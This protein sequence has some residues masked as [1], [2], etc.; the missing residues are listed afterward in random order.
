MR[1]KLILTPLG[2]KIKYRI[3]GKRFCKEMNQEQHNSG[4][5]SRDDLFWKSIF[6]TPNEMKR[7]LK[8]NKARSVVGDFPMLFDDCDY[9]R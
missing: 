7:F 4:T 1:V 8:R 5:Y 2:N 9:V 3:V 6:K